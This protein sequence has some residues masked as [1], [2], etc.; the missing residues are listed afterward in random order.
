MTTL[1]I[2]CA[3]RSSRFP[4]MK[5]KWMLTHPDGKIMIQKA[6][7]T[8]DLTKFSRVIVTI[9]RE[10][11]DKYDAVYVLQQ[12]FSFLNESDAFPKIEFCILDSFTASASETVYQTLQ[13][14]GVDEDFVVK[15]SDNQ[16]DFS[17]VHGN[18][19]VGCEATDFHLT[20][21]Q[22][23]SF[24]VCNNEGIIKKIVEKKIISSTVCLGVYGFQNPVLFGNCYKEL[25]KEYSDKEMYISVIVQHLINKGLEFK[26]VRASGYADWGTLTEWKKEQQ[27]L[28]TIFIDFDGVLIKNSGLFGRRNWGNNSELLLDN[29]KRVKELQDNGAQIIITTARPESY[30]AK[31]LELL[32]GVGIIP[33]A[34]VM[35]LNHAPR[36]LINDFAPTNPYPSA[37]A[38]NVPRDASLKDYI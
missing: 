2:P 34:M 15:D 12:A 7:E 31:V 4:N 30:R 5:P 36:F 26:Y 28:K 29:C 24:L 21:L 14:M 17:S 25:L 33:H 13:N 38:V 6:V 8:M 37:V 23:K 22:G 27:R 9:V 10:H 32:S 35:G 20:N 18:F 19:I 1:I 16:I 3:G 11:D